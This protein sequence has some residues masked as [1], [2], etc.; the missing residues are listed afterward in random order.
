MLENQTPLWLSFNTVVRAGGGA[1][2]GFAT[3]A[4]HATWVG[5]NLRASRSFRRRKAHCYCVQTAFSLLVLAGG[6]ARWR[7]RSTRRCHLAY[8]S[9]GVRMGSFN[10][11]RTLHVSPD[12]SI[13]RSCPCSESDGSAYA[14]KIH[15]TSR[16]IARI[17]QCCQGR[18]MRRP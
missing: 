18:A 16:W 5:F 6:F 8:V 7:V 14:C 15:A 10:L 1:K 11:C 13:V 2:H 3:F 9:F 17:V 12:S 4:G